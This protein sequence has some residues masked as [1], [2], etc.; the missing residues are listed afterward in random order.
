M[1]GSHLK[2]KT[3][4]HDFSMIFF[5]IPGYFSRLLNLVLAACVIYLNCYYSPELFLRQNIW[6][7]ATTSSQIS[8]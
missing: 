2:L 1:Q 7:H 3:T 8:G 4:F 6:A 5:M